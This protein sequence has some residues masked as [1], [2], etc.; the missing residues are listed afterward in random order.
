MNENLIDTEWEL[1]LD[2]LQQLV[3][4]RPADL[5]AVLFLIGVQE[6]GRGPRR[7]SKEAKQ[8]LM[9]IAVCRVL[10]QS[11]YYEFDGY[12]K[13]GWPQWKL[14]KP[15]PHADLLG[16]ESFLKRH[17]ILYFQRILV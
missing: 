9:H 6:L 17:V 8:D 2:Q 15:I 5:N 11:D 12:D 4:K 3:G 16:Q 10:S 1:L 7:F 14:L 13:D